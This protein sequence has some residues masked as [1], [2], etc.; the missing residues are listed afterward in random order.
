[1]LNLWEADGNYAN[2]RDDLIAGNS[3]VAHRPNDLG[4]ADHV[5]GSRIGDAPIAH[6]C[7]SWAG[8]NREHG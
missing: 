5:V 3:R 7:C 4:S 8:N 2:E 6:E 1:M